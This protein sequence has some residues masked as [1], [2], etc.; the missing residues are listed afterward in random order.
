M[1]FETTF[2][3]PA[4]RSLRVETGLVERP[5]VPFLGNPHVM[6]HRSPVREVWLTAS[7]GDN[8]IA[9]KVDALSLRGL[10]A[11]LAMIPEEAGE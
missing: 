4:E 7:D 6:L 11:V 1:K 9:I 3:F 8:K 5:D 10:R 2:R